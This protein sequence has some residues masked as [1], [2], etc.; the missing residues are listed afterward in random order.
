MEGI[1]EITRPS[2][3]WK[4]NDRRSPSPKIEDAWGP[5]GILGRKV[6]GTTPTPTTPLSEI[7]LP[8]TDEDYAEYYQDKISSTQQRQLYPLLE[9]LADWINKC[10]GI[11]YLQGGNLLDM[12]DNGVLLC[13]LAK[14]IQEKAEQ[15]VEAGL[16]SPPVP[17]IPS[18]CFKTAARR[19]FFSR[20]NMEKFILF[21]KKIGVH[22]NLLFES[23][24]LVLQ[25][26]PRNVILCLMEVSRLAT[27]FGVEPPGLVKFEREIAEEEESQ[28]DSGLSHDSISSWQLRE[29]PKPTSQPQRLC[30]SST[31]LNNGKHYTNNIIEN[32]DENIAINGNGVL[33]R[34]TSEYGPLNGTN[35]KSHHVDSAAEDE[36][37]RESSEE[38]SDY[39][40]TDRQSTDD[41]D[42]KVQRTTHIV[43]K[44]C[45]C[46]TGK[47]EK[48][49]VKKVGEGRYTIGGRNV[50]I[51]LLK[52]RHMMVRV[53]GGWDTLENFLAR[54][55]PCQSFTRSARNR[56]RP[57]RRTKGILKKRITFRL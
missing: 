15:A 26:K 9:D 57:Y 8:E 37:S 27:R 25:N 22:E 46:A 17:T 38:R 11:E 14:L 55:D 39:G 10:L 33:R 45:R 7:P 32:V 50:F 42:K 4:F 44:Q 2:N 49:Q 48:L 23:D 51:R 40:G 56:V 54:H 36:W 28:H 29:S 19:S 16:T 20:D 41:L 21:C 12:L 47:C 1:T 52:G 24:D 3:G 53:G 13:Q 5:P 30:S 6:L 34:T 31:S 18:R 43:R 35:G